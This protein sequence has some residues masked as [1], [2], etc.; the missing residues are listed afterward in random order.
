MNPKRRKIMS[1]PKGDNFTNSSLL[2]DA[3]WEIMPDNNVKGS[4]GIQLQPR[5][6]LI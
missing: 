5:D 6:M 1:N 4:V 2:V 3:R